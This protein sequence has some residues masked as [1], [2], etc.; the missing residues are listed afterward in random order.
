MDNLGTKFLLMRCE[1]CVSPSNDFIFYTGLENHPLTETYTFGA[2]FTYI[3][4]TVL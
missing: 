4:Q 1:N 2:L 3:S